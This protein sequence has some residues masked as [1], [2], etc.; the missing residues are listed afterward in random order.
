ME[1][2]ICTIACM[3][4]LLV[5][6]ASAL[7]AAMDQITMS[8]DELLQALAEHE[9]RSAV[10]ALAVRHVETTQVW[11]ADGAVSMQAWLRDR[12]R[13]SSADAGRWV[14]RGRFLD[15]FPVFAEALVSGT[16]S[17][18]QGWELQRVQMLE[19]DTEMW[20]CQ[21]VLADEIAPLPVAD[22]EKVC[23]HWRE[24]AEATVS[25]G[26]PPRVPDVEVALA[27]S[28]D[29]SLV[30]RLVLHD[31]AGRELEQALATARTWEGPGDA[32]SMATRNADALFD[33]CAFFNANHD[34]AGT[35]R[36]RPHLEV[37]MYAD[38]A[39]SSV[40]ADGRPVASHVADTLSCDCVVHRIVR[41][42]GGLP[43]S[44]GRAQYTVPRHL[45][46]AVA[47]RDGGCRFPGCDRPVRW[48]DAHHIQH[49]QHGGGTDLDN[50]VLLCSRHHHVVHQQRLGL[51]LC[52][53]AAVE[54]EWH[55][56]RVRSSRPR[57][58]ACRP[59]AS[60]PLGA[61]PPDTGPPD[62][63]PPGR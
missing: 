28:S 17:A 13:M 54:V 48:C 62:S 59:R 6:P 57:L 24:V 55:D 9:R 37:S 33:V 5:A 63:G 8:A 35:A 2:N 18:S 34:R 40:D 38:V 41:D 22:A 61:G 11:A 29:G 31:L 10:L 19:L 21:Q 36:H 1:S 50:P 49:W 26:K 4:D 15:R 30:G 7:D 39:D 42:D 27:W 32:R 43:L 56:G 58:G 60:A 52:D 16:L 51:R 23:R 25:A 12:A 14:R 45:F 20:M 44:Y 53:D 47:A 3:T 46:R